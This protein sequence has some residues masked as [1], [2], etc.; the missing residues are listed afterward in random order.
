MLEK[1]HFTLHHNV[2]LSQADVKYSKTWIKK[3]KG[4]CSSAF[5]N[6]YTPWE[7]FNK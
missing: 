7:Y 4:K 6:I 1:F 2:F 5:K 3:E